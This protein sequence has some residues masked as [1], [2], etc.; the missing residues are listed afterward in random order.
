MRG[1]LHVLVWVTAAYVAWLAMMAV[2][3]AG[4]VLHAWATGGRVVR[5]ELPLL[6][7]SRTDVSPNPR[8]GA[9]AWGGAVWGCL[10]P[11]AAWAASPRKAQR[12]RLAMQ[13][14]AGFCLIANG[15]YLGVGWIDGVGDAGDLMRHGTP[16]W[17]L[18][19]FGMTATGGGLYL[20][21]RLGAHA[22][23]NAP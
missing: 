2:H 5:V 11:L 3:E 18:V 13:L 12:V 14:F 19:A 16:A 1:A 7:F 21:H 6:G 9:V 23:A 17:V 4:H 10:L 15:I 20:W 22:A 8:P